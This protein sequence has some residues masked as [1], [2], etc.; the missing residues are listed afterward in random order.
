MD[1]EQINSINTQTG[2]ALVRWNRGRKS[3]KRSRP[4]AG[5]ESTKE[6]RTHIQAR[7]HTYAAFE[8]VQWKLCF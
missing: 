7:T 2:K 6:Q 5:Y 8:D 1:K 4:P 3:R